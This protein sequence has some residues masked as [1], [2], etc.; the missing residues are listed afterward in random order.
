MLTRSRIN[1]YPHDVLPASD[2][3]GFAAIT[4]GYAAPGFPAGRNVTLLSWVPVD[5]PRIV[6]GLPDDV[7]RPDTGIQYGPLW[8]I[9]SVLPALDAIVVR[10]RIDEPRLCV[11]WTDGVRIPLPDAVAEDAAA[12]TTALG[13]GVPFAVAARRPSSSDDPGV[14][15]DATRSVEE[16]LAAAMRL[17]PKASLVGRDLV[18]RAA[19]GLVE[20]SPWVRAAVVARAE[21]VLG[22]DAGR[23]FLSILR[24]PPGS[25]EA[26]ETNAHRAAFHALERRLPDGVSLARAG[27]ADRKEVA[28][29]RVQCA[30][31]LSRAESNSDLSPL[32][33]AV[34]DAPIDVARG[35]AGALADRRWVAGPLLLGLLGSYGAIDEVVIQFL[36]DH[37]VEGAGPRLA[38]LLGRARTTERR[39]A[40]I[41]ALRVQLG[42]DVGTE[43]SA[44]AAAF[45]AERPK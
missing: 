10:A 30:W 24:A 2:G 11:R 42:R 17:G 27:L 26:P 8:R 18:E 41:E 7:P 1:G 3:S 45:A 40:L 38:D 32:V 5:G 28:W 29:A 31:V 20:V 14:V 37:V 19:V 36:C 12:A 6:V 23:V 34:R 43:A 16:R 21:R 35:A 13:D 44:W 4:S 9:Q 22:S 33:A 39:D 25:V 15:A